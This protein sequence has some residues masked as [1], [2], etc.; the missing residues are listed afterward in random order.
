MQRKDGS[1][2]RERER[3][4]FLSRKERVHYGILSTGVKANVHN[5][6]PIYVGKVGIRQSIQEGGAAAAFARVAEE[7]DFHCSSLEFPS[8]LTYEGRC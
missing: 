3:R 5:S 2:E 6:G 8:L 7:T 1:G 4:E